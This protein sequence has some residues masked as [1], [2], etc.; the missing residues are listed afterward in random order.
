VA[1][2]R[3]LMLAGHLDRPAWSTNRS[4][5]NSNCSFAA[6]WPAGSVMS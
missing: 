5:P 1:A 2:I 3:H 4:R 6:C